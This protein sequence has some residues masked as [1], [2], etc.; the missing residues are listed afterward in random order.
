MTEFFD[1]TFYGNTIAEW[2][3]ALLIIVGTFVLAKAL[4]WVS[5]NIIKKLTKK[6]KSQLD[7]LIVDKIEE[8]IILALVLGGFWFGVA[9]LNL[10]EGFAAFMDKA[11]YVA[12]TFDVSWLIVR[13]VD[14]IIVEYLTPLVKKTDGDLDDQLLPIIRKSLKAVIWI[15][16]IVVGLNNAGYDVGAL[17]AGLGLGGL[18]FAMAAKDSVAN[19]FGG[20]SVFMDKPFKIN[21]R[22]QLDGFD[23]TITDI[24]LRSTKLKTLNGRIVTI[25]NHKFTGSYIENVSSEPSRKMALSLGLTYDMTADDIQRGIEILKEIDKNSKYTED[26]CVAIFETFGDFSLNIT[27]IYYIKPGED[28]W[29][30]INDTNFEILRKFNEAKLGFAFPTQTIITQNN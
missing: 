29:A 9:Y 4:Y 22:I 5:G 3:V 18:A 1:K 14:A 11:F 8:P 7:D 21:D 25:P 20:V 13:L 10:S 2:L 30:A 19:L 23:G 6:S 12:I 16:A 26:E 27:Y 15:V 17:I 24:G 28:I